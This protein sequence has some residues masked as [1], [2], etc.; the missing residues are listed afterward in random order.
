MTTLT[1]PF[2]PALTPSRNGTTDSGPLQGA[3]MANFPALSRQLGASLLVTTYPAAY[4]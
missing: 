4:L 1:A 3:H 2:D